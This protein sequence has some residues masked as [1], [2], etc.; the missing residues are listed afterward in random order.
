MLR[1]IELFEEIGIQYLIENLDPSRELEALDVF[2][3]NVIM[4]MS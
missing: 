1:Q 2:K 4:K 3:D